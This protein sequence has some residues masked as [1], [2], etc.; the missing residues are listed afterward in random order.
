[1]P[2][3]YFPQG[4]HFSYF[5]QDFKKLPFL[6]SQPIGDVVNIKHMHMFVKRKR[7]MLYS[8][9]EIIDKDGVRS[10]VDFQ[11]CL[12]IC[13]C[14]LLVE[15]NKQRKLYVIWGSVISFSNWIALWQNHSSECP[16]SQEKIR[17]SVNSDISWEDL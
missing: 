15:T 11:R 4:Y 16:N 1:M 8:V 17:K 12:L 9:S 5:I 10:V 3:I 7:P 14:S 6:R 2:S 13:L